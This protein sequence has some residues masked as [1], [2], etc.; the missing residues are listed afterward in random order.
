MQSHQKPSRFVH[1]FLLPFYFFLVSGSVQAQTAEE[2]KTEEDRVLKSCRDNLNAQKFQEGLLACQ[3]ALEDFKKTDNLR[4]QGL[5][6]NNIGVNYNALDQYQKAI[7]N[8]QQSLKIAREIKDQRLEVRSLGNLGLAY[9]NLG[10]YDKAIKFQLQSLAIARE[11]K[12]RLGEGQSLGNLGLA[13]YSLGKYDKAI[14]FQL[15]RLVIAREIKDRLGEGASLGNLGLAYDALGKYDKAIEFHLQHLAIAREIKD[16]SGEGNALGNLGAA[17][18]SLGK[19]DK[20][21]EFHLQ[22]LAIAREIKD[23]SGEGNALGNLGAAYYSLGKYDKA[24]EFHLQFLAIARE[25]KDRLGEGISL[26]NL[27]NAYYSLG[28]YDKAIEFHLQFLAIAREI[29]DRLGEGISLGNLGIAYYNLGKYDKAI[30]FQQQRLAIAREI[31]DRSGE[32]ISLNNLA[33]AF[34]NLNQPELAILF[35]KQSVNAIEAI[36]QD[37]R[38]LDKDIQKSY[39]ATVEKT[40]RNL[41]D[42]LLKQDRI[43]EAQQVLDLLKVQELSDYL[44]TVRGNNQTSQGVDLQRPEQNIIALAS[45]LN[46]LQQKDREGKLNQTEEQRLAQLVQAERD[47][48]KQFNAFLDSPEIKKLITELRRVEEQ[49]NLN[50]ASYRKLQKDVLSQIPN[51]VLLYP[52]ILDDRLELIIINAKTPPLRR[53]INVKREQLNQEI[54]DFLS[55]LRDAGSEDIKESAQKLYKLLIQPFEAELQELKIDTIIYAP[56]GQLRYIPLSALHDGKQWLAEKYRVNNITAE[57]LTSFA[58]KPLAKPRIFAGAF[59]GK[60][61]DKTRAGFDGLPATITE[62]QK[63][64]SLF[65]NTTT[66]T[67]T[68]FSKQITETKA[69][70]HTIL[71][72]ATHGELSVGTPEDSFI[73]FGNGEKATIREI[74]DWSLSNVDLVILS[75]CQSG[76]GSKLGTGIEI[77]GLGYQMQS[78]GARVAIA[79]LWKVDDA[80]TQ[81]L[82]TAFYGE[83][84]K[85]DV[86]VTEALRRAQV[87]L[88][89]SPNYNHPNYWS[90]FFA[91]GNGL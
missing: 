6:L 24:I 50:L 10:K 64:A 51:A 91:I 20:A 11:I 31:K 37:V 71:H 26:G 19:Y 47:Q 90:A 28:K 22:R 85:G 53:T 78:A 25:I 44:K 3:A 69:N 21:I 62:V 17:Y 66:L 55:E 83:L 23:R 41:A 46:Q 45:E 49:Q 63:I 29:K 43:L 84:Q 16:R 61:G 9:S 33:V 8:L 4:G 89:K 13:Y 32:G 67:E 52:L 7:D 39:L 79:S 2:R 76:I 38:K 65:P 77:L 40:Y 72:L 34:K 60:L 57:S 59:G 86:T 30:E 82:M 36:R 56:D 87:A 70:S 12:D 5:A 54:I 48:N 14:E 1:F 68:S 73:L 80:G 42:L 18:Y 15:Q 75:A 74:Q 58:P 27:G 88:I 81:A 35:Y